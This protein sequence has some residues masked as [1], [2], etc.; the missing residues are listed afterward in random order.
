MKNESEKCT[1]IE[2]GEAE[3]QKIQ[4]KKCNGQKGNN[5]QVQYT[6]I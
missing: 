4:G 3:G 2:A 6:G 5:S 1:K